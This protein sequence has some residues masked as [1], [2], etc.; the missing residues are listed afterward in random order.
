MIRGY[1]RKFLLFLQF[2]PIW[3]ILLKCTFSP[4]HDWHVSEPSL[5]PSANLSVVQAGLLSGMRIWFWQ[6]TGS[7][8]LYLKRRKILKILWNEYFRSFQILLFC[9][10]TSPVSPWAS[11]QDPDPVRI[12]P[13]PG[14]FS[15]SRT[16]MNVWHQKYE[17][18]KEGFKN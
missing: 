3:V 10:Q 9:F 13:D 18:K 4:R 8:A 6:K 17:N 2:F 14:W 5:Q 7:G 15:E 11:D 12:L 1:E 16:S